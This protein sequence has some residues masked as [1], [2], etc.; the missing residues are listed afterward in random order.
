MV[1]L[2]IFLASLYLVNYSVNVVN[3][4]NGDVTWDVTKRRRATVSFRI[5]SFSVLISRSSPES[6]FKNEKPA[7]G[8]FLFVSTVKPLRLE[9][10]P[11]E[12]SVTVSFR[13]VFA[14]TANNT[15][16]IILQFSKFYANSR[17][18]SSGKVPVSLHDLSLK[19]IASTNHQPVTM[20]LA[21]I[22]ICWINELNP[23]SSSRPT[24]IRKFNCWLLAV[25]I[26]SRSQRHSQATSPAHPL[27]RPHSSHHKR[28][29]RKS[30]WVRH[31]FE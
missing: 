28:I 16:L 4:V 7:V 11:R 18:F 15:N 19:W 8:D 22:Q 20:V 23:A 31:S 9:M 24:A 17:L 5:F 2:G 12:C 21:S 30:F 27:H 1:P 26:L 10:W 14:P 29:L 13:N 3:I 6:A 25:S